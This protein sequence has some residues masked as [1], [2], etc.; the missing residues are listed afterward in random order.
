MVALFCLLGGAASGQA[1]REPGL[2]KF[3]NSQYEPVAWSELEG[4]ASDDHILGFKT[5]LTS[6]KAILPQSA[7]A[8]EKR[9]VFAALKQICRDAAIA[10]P[11]D[12]E[13]AR[14]FLEKNFRPLRIAPLGEPAG[15][16]TGYYEPVVE[17]SRY[18]TEEY[19]IPLYRK[20]SNLVA[21]GR[22]TGAENFPNKGPV[23][24]KVGRRKMA[25]YYDRAEIEEGALAGRGLEICWLKDPVDLFFIQIQGSAR[26]KLNDGS[27]LR[28]NYEAHNGYSYTAVGKF[29]IDWG[30]PRDEISLDRIR[31]WM[32]ENPA[33]GKELRQKNRSY[34]FFRETG[35]GEKD[36]PIGA[37]GIPVT[38]GRSIAVDRA[39]HVYGTP[40][41]IEADL[42]I[43]GPQPTTKFRR[44]MVAQD[45]G[46]AIVGPARADIYFGAGPELGSVAGRIRHPGRFAMLIPRALDPV[47]AGKQTLLPRPKPILLAQ[48]E[49]AKAGAVP[50]PKPQAKPAPA[51][52]YKR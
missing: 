52:R 10:A 41:F 6:C 45:T 5:F 20:P 38:A 18:H 9:P 43:D 27:L 11:A 8:R 48:N 46:S 13:Q 2:I 3:A 14:G 44:L 25:P 50:L 4:W 17:G 36:E 15:F 49:A 26:V 24:R 32:E 21:G 7:S 35:L 1:V 34:V 40:F 37:Q 29:L 19:N 51:K 12:D 39:I 16:L 23:G 31:H 30:V 28:V 47:E 33:R 22:R 42:P